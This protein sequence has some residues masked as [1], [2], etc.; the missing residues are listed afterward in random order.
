MG[1][2]RLLTALFAAALVVSAAGEIT[3]KHM[4]VTPYVEDH[5]NEDELQLAIDDPATVCGDIIEILPGASRHN[6]YPYFLRGP[7]LAPELG[8]PVAQPSYAKDCASSGKYI[9]IRSSMAYQLTPGKRVGAADAA[10]LAFVGT[11]NVLIGSGVGCTIFMTDRA[12]SFY[13]LQGLELAPPD[14]DCSGGG[15]AIV[16]ITYESPTSG[17]NGLSRVDHFPHHIIIDQCWIHGV[18]GYPARNGVQIEGVTISL[19]NSTIENIRTG[20]ATG[21]Q[22]SEAISG[23][24]GGGPVRIVNNKISGGQNVMIFGGAP[25]P[26]KRP[27]EYGEFSNNW[28]YRPHKWMNWYGPTDPTPLSPCPV[29]SDA[30]GATYRNTVAVTYWECQ[31]SA[32]GTWTQL[33][34]VGAYNALVDARQSYPG[35]NPIEFKSSRAWHM[36]GNLIDQF[37]NNNLSGQH[38]SCLQLALL[39]GIDSTN[40]GF[41]FENNICQHAGWG[42]AQ[43]QDISTF[44]TTG[45]TKYWTNNGYAT[46][47]ILIRNNLYQHMGEDMLTGPAFGAVDG[48]GTLIGFEKASSFVNI[49]HYWADAVTVD[50][51]TFQSEFTGGNSNGVVGIMAGQSLYA[52][53]MDFSYDPA[54]PGINQRVTNNIFTA[55]KCGVSDISGIGSCGVNAVS[56]SWGPHAEM[57]ANGVIDALGLGLSSG[58][59]DAMRY[60]CTPGSWGCPYSAIPTDPPPNMLGYKYAASPSAFLFTS[61]PDDLS[62]QSTSP[63]KA[64]G[65]DGKDLG[66]DLNMVG[67]ATAGAQAGT[68]APYLAMK[69]RSVVTGATSVAVRFS[70]PDISSCTVAARK[71][72]FP[73]SSA[74]SSAT[75]SSGTLDRLVTLTGLSGNTK[76]GLKVTCAGSYYREDE[77]RTP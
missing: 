8:G 14:G 24:A 58:L 17:N 41:I 27:I 36:E 52:G 72:G 22:E 61:Y 62:L 56:V 48:E 18:E 65:L 55:G 57:A 59:F 33:A 5:Y 31:G 1:A 11:T 77:F 15:R 32:P 3:V 4:S 35:K 13:R 39:N 50:H 7:A 28:L 42:F 34:N 73:L 10:N 30:H 43:G 29:D 38:A 60:H 64:A 63:L 71:Y 19:I 75:D 9:T 20:E 70:A 66:A 16:R 51:N 74:V 47:N 21:F 68:M 6:A 46:H 45:E 26:T 25:S 54:Q 67:W 37:S 44:N 69:I 23:A 40:E 53:H 49:G 76:Y 12:A 2:M